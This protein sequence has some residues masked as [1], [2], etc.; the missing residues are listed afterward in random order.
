[1]SNLTCGDCGYSN[2]PERVYCHNCGAK[3]DRSVLPEDVRKPSDSAET[4]RRRVKKFT[5]PGRFTFGRLVK[6]IF[7]AGL[8]GFLAATLISAILPPKDL[9][10]PVH[11]TL[12][13]PIVSQEMEDAVKAGRPVGF[14]QAQINAYLARVI[15]AQKSDSWVKYERTFVRLQPGLAWTT[16][17]FSV[18]GYPLYDTV[19]CRMPIV[20]GKPVPESAGGYF[21]RLPIHPSIMPL[22]T[23]PFQTLWEAL[24]E[25]RKLLDRMKATEI[26]EKGVLLIPDT[27]GG[28]RPGA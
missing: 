27:A 7:S 19:G 10:A 11:D 2:E 21:G 15:R 3:L 13:A 24:K 8:Y 4:V 22:L 14:T 26:S 25:E 18:F 6:M 23:K 28:S 12:D 1:M 17:Q 20:D 16:L 9:P 5:N